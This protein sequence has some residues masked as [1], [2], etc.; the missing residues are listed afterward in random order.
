MMNTTKSVAERALGPLKGAFKKQLQSL[1][2]DRL[3]PLIQGLGFQWIPEIILRG[4]I[5][6]GLLT[7]CGSFVTTIALLSAVQIMGYK[8]LVHWG[9]VQGGGMVAG[10]LVVLTDS[11][12]GK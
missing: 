11:D 10:A 8:G 5:E 6:S 12:L 9:M 7:V 1:G 2:S 4:H 3:V